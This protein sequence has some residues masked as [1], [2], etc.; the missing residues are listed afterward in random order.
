MYG[1]EQ[2]TLQAAK[3]AVVAGPRA[4]KEGGKMRLRE[5][6]RAAKQQSRAGRSE[7]GG[8]PNNGDR[9]SCKTNKTCCCLD[10]A[11]LR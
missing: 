8:T 4:E 9:P 10:N 7:R 3:F 5:W 1:V 2:A 6:K 11:V